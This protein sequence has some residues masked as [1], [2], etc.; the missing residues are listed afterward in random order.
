[1]VL[2]SRYMCHWSNTIFCFTKQVPKGN[3]TKRIM[4]AK[5][6]VGWILI[7]FFFLVSEVN[8]ITQRCEYFESDFHWSIIWFILKLMKP[9]NHLNQWKYL[10]V[11]DLSACFNN[12][13]WKLP[14]NHLWFHLASVFLLEFFYCWIHHSGTRRRWFLR[15]LQLIVKSLNAGLVCTS[16]Y[17]IL[18]LQLFK[19]SVVF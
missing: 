16:T 14:S 1:M 17:C 9:M 15:L 7:H 5:S 6:W 2:G 12:N 13:F 3:L 4:K 18:L 11:Y 8:K 10:E 19:S